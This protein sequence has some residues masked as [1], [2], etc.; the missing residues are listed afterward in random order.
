MKKF[1]FLSAVLALVGLS[2]A[3]AGTVVPVD[4]Y[5]ASTSPSSWR[6]SSV[7]GAKD[8]LVLVWLDTLSA[9][10]SYTVQTKSE[11]SLSDSG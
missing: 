10:V 5:I 2:V 8:Y 3:G 1:L 4:W 7:S 11:Y 6:W 9:P